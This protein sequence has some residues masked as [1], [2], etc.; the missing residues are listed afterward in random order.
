MKLTKVKIISFAAMLVG[1]VLAFIGFNKNSDPM[2]CAKDLM[3]GGTGKPGTIFI[4][5]G[6]VA[7]VA[8]GVLLFLDYKKNKKA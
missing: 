8:G 6:V 1:I 3:N 2:A 7:I 4:I 5:I